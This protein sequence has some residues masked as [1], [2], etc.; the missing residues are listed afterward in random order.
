MMTISVTVE[1]FTCAVKNCLNILFKV[2]TPSVVD[3]PGYNTSIADRVPFKCVFMKTLLF[4]S[5]KP[6]D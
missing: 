4:T 1:G 5:A 6:S 2:Y 3:I